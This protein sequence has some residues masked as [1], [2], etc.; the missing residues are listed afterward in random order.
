MTA[1][2]RLSIP[3]ALAIAEAALAVHKPG[4]MILGAWADARGVAVAHGF[5]ENVVTVGPGPLLV[6]RVSGEVSFLGSIEQLDRLNAMREVPV[7]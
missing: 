4:E 2:K 1:A 3:E 5:S 7:R 6:D